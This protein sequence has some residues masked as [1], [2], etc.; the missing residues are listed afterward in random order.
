MICPNNDLHI[1]IPTPRSTHISDFNRRWTE[2]Y[3][4]FALHQKVGFFI[5]N[6]IRQFIDGRGNSMFHRIIELERDKNRPTY[7]SHHQL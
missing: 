6:L 3:L 2:F 4:A 7:N 5:L 1:T